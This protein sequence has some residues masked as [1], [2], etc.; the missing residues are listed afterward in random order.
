MIVIIKP[1][2]TEKTV[3]HAEGMNQYTFEVNR[4]VNKIEVKT[5]IEK[6]YS[7]KV[8]KVRIINN[9]GKS[10]F[11]GRKRIKGKKSDKKKA[12][13]TLKKGD[14]ISAFNIK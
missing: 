9:L 4:D 6:K 14:K 3:T 11:F 8:D 2:I 12:I 1:I 13:V 10:V 5:A 7:V